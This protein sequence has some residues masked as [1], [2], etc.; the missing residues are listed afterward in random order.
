MDW[1]CLPNGKREWL[2]ESAERLPLGKSSPIKQRKRSDSPCENLTF[3]TLMLVNFRIIDPF[4]VRLKRKRQT[5]FTSFSSHYFCVSKNFCVFCDFC[6]THLSPSGEV[7]PRSLRFLRDIS[8]SQLDEK[9]GRFLTEPTITLS[10]SGNKYSS[11]QLLFQRLHRRF[12]YWW[13][14]AE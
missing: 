9:N 14:Q 10:I 11:S 7:F 1:L 13:R 12:D 3:F 6:V 4:I 5:I 8:L 2:A